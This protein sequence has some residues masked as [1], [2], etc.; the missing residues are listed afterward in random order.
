[1]ETKNI[2]N[3]FSQDEFKNSLKNLGEKKEIS[4][5]DIDNLIGLKLNQSKDFIKNREDELKWSFE[6]VEFL[7]WLWDKEVSWIDYIL[8]KSLNPKNN[9][10]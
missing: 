9:I 8:S 1:M 3:N 10:A 5:K 2:E 7:S 4:S 6:I